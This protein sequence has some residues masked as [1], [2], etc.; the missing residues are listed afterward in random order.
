MFFTDAR[1]PAENLVGELNQGWRVANG[2]LGHERTMMWLGF[3]DR[4]E[5]MLADF[6]PSTE[7]ERDQYATTIMETSAAPV[8][9]GGTSP[10]RPRRRRR[11]RDLGAQ[12]ARVRGRAAWD[13][14]ALTSAGPDGLIHPVRPARMRI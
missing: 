2:S 14:L 5:N 13:G 12:A 8:G 3:A 7:V 9:L 4:M 11:G 6:H 1:V 10:R